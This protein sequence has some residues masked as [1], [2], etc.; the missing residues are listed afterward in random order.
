MK[1]DVLIAGAGPAGLAAAVELRRSGAGRVLVLDRETTPGGVPRHCLHTGYGLRDLRRLLDGPAYARRYADAA[2]AAGA[3]VQA[4]STDTGWTGDRTVTVT[5][6]R[7]VETVAVLLAKGGRE[8]PRTARLVPGGRPRGVMTTVEL[9][10]RVYLGGQR[11]PG[12]A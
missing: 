10:Q 12:R 2:A 3:D 9:E 7:G 5:R 6:A 1:V 11:L 4:G 8:L